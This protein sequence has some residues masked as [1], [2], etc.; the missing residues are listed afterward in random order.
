MAVLLCGAVIEFYRYCDHQYER[1]RRERLHTFPTQGR[2]ERA[3]LEL[4]AERLSVVVAPPMPPQPHPPPSQNPTLV[5][6][7]PPRLQFTP[8]EPK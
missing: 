1:I 2:V 5:A 4:R 3:T 8:P 6:D 7:Y